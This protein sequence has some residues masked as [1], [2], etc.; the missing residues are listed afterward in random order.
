MNKDDNFV[1]ILKF[2]KLSSF[3]CSKDLK[4]L[5]ST[6][7]LR[8]YCLTTY[9]VKC[10]SLAS[11]STISG[12]RY[13]CVILCSLL[14]PCSDYCLISWDLIFCIIVYFPISPRLAFPPFCFT[15]FLHPFSS[16]KRNTVPLLKLLFEA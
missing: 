14:F 4:Y 10:I 16:P 15:F 13:V 12:S 9:N 5:L 8:F 3:M 2:P 1:Q 6:K 11:F 7:V